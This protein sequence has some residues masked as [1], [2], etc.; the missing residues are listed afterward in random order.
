[1][2]RL[3]TTPPDGPERSPAMLAPPPRRGPGVRRLNRIPLVIAFLVACAVA[4]AIGYT[5]Q[6]RL[7][8]AA[9]N[10]RQ[11]AEH[12]AEPASAAAILN[13]APADGEARSAG[14]RP[15]S[16]PPASPER[17][18]QAAATPS[19]RADG[20]QSQKND[21]ATKARREAWQNYYAQLAQLQKHRLTAAQSA[22]TADTS[23][24]NRDQSVIS[25]PAGGAA[26]PP[27]AAEPPQRFSAATGA[28]PDTGGTAAEVPDVSGAALAGFPIYPPAQIDGAGQREK[29]AFLSQPGATGNGDYLQARRRDPI[30]PYEV[31]A[32]TFIPAVMIGGINSDVPGMIVG[33][34]AENVYD[35]ATGRY[36]LIP[37]GAKLIGAYDNT[38]SQ[39]QTRVVVIWN[40]IIY[41]DASSIDLGSMP[42][43]DEGGYPGFH[44]RVD[45]HLG[46]KLGN[47]VLLSI[48]TAGVQLSQPQAVNG[49]N[50]NSQQIAAAALGQQFAQLGHEYARA[51]LAIPNTLEVSPGY[52]FV[53]MVNK[54]MVLRPWSAGQTGVVSN[55]MDKSGG[56]R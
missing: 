48:A 56:F 5:Y 6:Q 8:K 38:I 2:I 31:K 18:P 39:G 30:S 44:D 14:S 46:A 55:P 34:V 21:A 3:W 37:Q 51:G 28:A 26:A 40:R 15:A 13:S 20:S 54:D 53:V 52:R 11:D 32:G 16:P 4:G 7:L 41:P 17:E 22:M 50:Y 36:L 43:A 29:R 47:A 1:M 25:A 12:K 10:A 33:Q 9:A 45:T 27:A 49:Q 42:G 19:D 23:A 24:S 35:T